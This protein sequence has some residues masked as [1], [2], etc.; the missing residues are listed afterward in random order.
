MGIFG[1]GSRKKSKTKK[2]RSKGFETGGH[3]TKYGKEELKKD[4]YKVVKVKGKQRIV[5]SSFLF[6]SILCG[7]F[8]NYN[9][10]LNRLDGKWSYFQM[11]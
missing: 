9:V 2:G 10:C 7:G 5:P 11:F 3:I 8:Q 4:G 1:F 6:T